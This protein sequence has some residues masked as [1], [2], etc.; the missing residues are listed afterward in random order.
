MRLYGAEDVAENGDAALDGPL[1]GVAKAEHQLRRVRGVVGAVGAAL[2]RLPMSSGDGA[3]LFACP[4]TNLKE[5][6]HG[7]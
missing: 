1:A 7:P 3:R 4:I 5:N 6:S 2:L